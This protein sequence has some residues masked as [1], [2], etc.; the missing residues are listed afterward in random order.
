MNVCVF[1]SSNDLEKK[2]IKPAAELARLLAESGHNLIYGG[3]DYGLM[4]VMA[5][6]MQA[7]GAQVVGVTIPVYAAHARKNADEM[8]IAKTLGERKAVILERSD[9]IVT[10]VGGIGTLD[11]LTELLELKRQNHHNK[12]IVVLN[13]DGFWN[14]LRAQLQRMADEKLFKPG[15]N[16]HI[17]TKTLDEFIRFVDTPAEVM[18]LLGVSTAA[19]PVMEVLETTG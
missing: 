17:P 12:A 7:G 6:G 15:E 11:E 1:C 2:Y 16:K 14:G 13:T 4:K 8:I 18:E 3:S 5:N 10:L 9:A 19:A